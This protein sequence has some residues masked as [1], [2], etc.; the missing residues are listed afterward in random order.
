MAVRISTSC[1]LLCP[2]KRTTHKDPEIFSLCVVVP[3]L[4][5]NL[6]VVRIHGMLSYGL[7]ALDV[8]RANSHT[9]VVALLEASDAGPQRMA[10]QRKSKSLTSLYGHKDGGKKKK[11]RSRWGLLPGSSSATDKTDKSGRMG[12]ESRE[13]RES[14]DSAASGSSLIGSLGKSKSWYAP[15]DGP[16]AVDQKDDGSQGYGD[17]GGG[18][19]WGSSPTRK[20]TPSDESAMGSRKGDSFSSRLRAFAR[21]VAMP[22]TRLSLSPFGADAIR[23]AQRRSG[24][25]GASGSSGTGGGSGKGGAKVF[26]TFSRSVSMESDAES[27]DTVSASSRGSVQWRNSASSVSSASTAGSSTSIGAFARGN[28]GGGGGGGHPNNLSV[29]VEDHDLSSLDGGRSFDGFDGASSID[30]RSPN[31]PRDGRRGSELAP[32]RPS[33]GPPP[34]AWGYDQGLHRQQS[35]S[36]SSSVG[37]GG[38]GGNV[39]NSPVS[40]GSFVSKRPTDK[41]SKQ[42]LAARRNLKPLSHLEDMPVGVNAFPAPPPAKQPWQPPQ[43]AKSTPDSAAGEEAKGGAAGKARPVVPPSPGFDA[44]PPAPTGTITT[45]ASRRSSSAQ[46]P[47]HARPSAPAGAN[48]PTP[49]PG[50]ALLQMAMTSPTDQPQSLWPPDPP[51]GGFGSGGGGGLRALSP[52]GSARSVSTSSNRPVHRRPKAAAA[53]DGALTAGSASAATDG[54]SSSSPVE[55]APVRSFAIARA[56]SSSFSSSDAAAASSSSASSVRTHRRGSARTHGSGDSVTGAAAAADTAGGVFGAGDDASGGG[57]RSGASP[58]KCATSTRPRPA[59]RVRDRAT[60]KAARV[61]SAPG[62]PLAPR[63]AGRYSG[64]D[65]LESLDPNAVSM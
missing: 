8:A 35:V 46:T 41:D 38:G 23:E 29:I 51:V 61:K 32:G 59:S 34:G 39:Q 12:R 16:A 56:S 11:H 4:P 60:G 54:T 62:G 6:P 28:C 2:A 52:V 27:T 50:R 10:S 45:T 58:L 42:T 53:A 64:D 43:P 48:V 17:G 37:G 24:T 44:M 33:K 57:S 19:G 31:D 15:R 21:G 14:T 26:Q 5:V 40:M 7:T 49:S 36:P 47:P 20:R 22:T 65:D 3:K 18:G 13:S 55:H 63:A 25:P 1:T 9:S 30:P